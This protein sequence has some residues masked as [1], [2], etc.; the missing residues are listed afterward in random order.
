MTAYNSIDGIPCTANRQLLTDLLKDQ[1]QFRG[2]FVVSDLVSIDGIHENHRVAKTIAEAAE[3]ALWAGVDVDL[4][5]NAYIKLTEAVKSNRIPE[6]LIDSA[7]SRV[8]RL[9]FEMGGLFENPYVDPQKAKTTVRNPQHVSL[10]R[11]AARQSVILLENKNNILPLGK[12]IKRVAVIGLMPIIDTTSWEIIRPPQDDG[13]IKTV[14]DGIKTMLPGAR[15]DYVKGCA[16]RDTTNLEI[17]EAVEAARNADVAIV[18]VGG[19]SARDFK[20]EYLETGAAIATKESVSDIESG[21]G[22]DRSTLDLL[23]KQSDLLKAVKATGTPLIVIYIQGRPLNMNWASQ[24]ADALLT[25]WYPGQ[26]GGNAMADV[27]FGD[28]NPAGRLPVSVPKSVGQIPVYYNKK[29][30]KGHDY[31]ETDS[32][33]LY[34]FGYGLSYTRFEYKDTDVKQ[35]GLYDFEVSFT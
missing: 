26:E 15:I 17:E 35:N 20:T 13:N 32:S 19:S 14:L 30:P 23:G 4:G 1:W 3:L 12:D 6:A 34:P 16:I 31:V 5:A 22:F 9:K 25:A 18:V 11:E 21:E 24:H 28:Y 10:A 33:P 7:V 29:N 27:L 2:G 8:L